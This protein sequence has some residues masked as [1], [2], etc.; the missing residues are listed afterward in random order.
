MQ[1]QKKLQHQLPV[2]LILLWTGALLLLIPTG[3]DAQI[4]T[5]TEKFEDTNNGGSRLNIN[6]RD[7]VLTTIKY[8]ERQLNA[9][10][11][12]F[13]D[14]AGYSVPEDA[15]ITLMNDQRHG[16]AIMLLYSITNDV[17]RW[18]N[19]FGKHRRFSL[20]MFKELEKHIPP[21]DTSW[22]LWSAGVDTTYD[23]A[24]EVDKNSRRWLR[25][26]S[27]KLR[28]IYPD[29][30][31]DEDFTEESGTGRKTM[32]IT[33]QE[34]AARRLKDAYI[35]LKS[36]Y[37]PYLELNGLRWKEDA[38]IEIIKHEYDEDAVM[39]KFHLNKRT[40]RSDA[41][42]QFHKNFAEEISGFMERKSR[43]FSTDW[44]KFRVTADTSNGRL[45]PVFLD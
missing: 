3:S 21:E 22:V 12:K 41:N 37:K 11:E 45:A 30:T 34:Y 1:Y 28:Y 4:R 10:Y 8:R 36:V 15:E 32:T 40:Q 2:V 35:D 20:M 18:D 17:A 26:L 43:S 29:Y 6:K 16:D 24:E 38:H 31:R 9:L 33:A 23:P 7:W 19:D 39:V 42:L 27:L 44:L 14:D 13:I 25:T 5:V